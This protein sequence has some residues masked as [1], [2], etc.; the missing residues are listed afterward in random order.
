V[1]ET[2][3]ILDVLANGFAKHS[4]RERTG[5]AESFTV[6]VAWVD[7]N[8]NHAG[9]RMT[10]HVSA[11]VSVTV[12][13]GCLYHYSHELE[14]ANRNWGVRLTDVPSA[15]WALTPSSFVVDWFWGVN[16]F[17][18]AL[19]PIA[20]LVTDAEW[21]VV[22][23][24]IV[25]TSYSSDWTLWSDPTWKSRTPATERTYLLLK[26]V[27]RSPASLTPSI[28][29]T[30]LS[31]GAKSLAFGQAAGLLALFTQKLDPLMRDLGPFLPKV[32]KGR[33]V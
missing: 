4:P 5:A 32:Q 2:E 31:D 27:R 17:I 29:R 25:L 28:T 19:T 30:R 3:Q 26:E 10:R 23:K 20:G 21:T 11:T 14:A 16:S 1:R 24:T 8:G 7:P 12:K 9:I 13:A 15:L 33:R 22:H 6:P 18:K